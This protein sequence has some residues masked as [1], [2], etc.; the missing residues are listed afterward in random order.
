[1]EEAKPLL[2][3]HPELLTDNVAMFTEGL[4]EKYLQQLCLLFRINI[5]PPT[6]LCIIKSHPSNPIIGVTGAQFI[7]DALTTNT[8]LTKLVLSGLMK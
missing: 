8:T 2:D 3:R 4:E 5:I 1:M 6:E 7:S